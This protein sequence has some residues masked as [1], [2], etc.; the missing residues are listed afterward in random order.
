M[1][2]VTLGETLFSF[3]IEWITQAV[4]AVAGER[5]EQRFGVGVGEQEGQTLRHP[6]LNF[7]DSAFVVARSIRV[8]ELDVTPLRKCAGGLSCLY[9]DQVVFGGAVEVR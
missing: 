3:G 2:N 5:I 8:D 7:S 9:V 6:L 4:S 1:A